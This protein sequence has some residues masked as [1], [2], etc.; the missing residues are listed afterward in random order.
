MCIA[1][2][3]GMDR[4]ETHYRREADKLGFDLKIFNRPT[5]DTFIKDRV[6]RCSHYFH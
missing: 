3:G 4:L 5:T 2:I 1:I 6:C